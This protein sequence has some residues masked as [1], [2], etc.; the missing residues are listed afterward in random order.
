MR[1]PLWFVVIGVIAVAS[2]VAAALYA[3]PRLDT[4][5][6]DMIRVVVP[7]NAVLEL[8][9][10]GDYV[11]YHE[12][13]STVDGRYYA[14]DRVEGL[15]V[16]LTTDTGA[17]VPVGEPKYSATYSIGNRSG[18]SIYSFTVDRPGRYRLVASLEGGRTE[19]KAVL[20]I[21]QGTVWGIFRLVLGT[22]A[23]AFGGIGVAAV[24]LFVVLW[25]RSKK[26]AT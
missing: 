3:M 1:S 20:A 19:P 23:I 15:R 4:V 7:G 22:L 11:V 9:K 12:K 21:G 13:H 16:R 25:R 17:E 14:S 5:G 8:D 6:S 10:P 2:I 24:L 26:V 18:T